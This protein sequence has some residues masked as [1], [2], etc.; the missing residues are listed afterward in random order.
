[1]E[2]TKPLAEYLKQRG[3]KK[4]SNENILWKAHGTIKQSK[5]LIKHLNIIQPIPI[6]ITIL[7]YIFLDNLQLH[8]S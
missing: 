7:K 3:W 2:K 6:A 1:M 8:H 5:Y 4:K